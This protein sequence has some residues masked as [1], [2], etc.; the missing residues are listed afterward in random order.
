MDCAIALH[1]P[2]WHRLTVVVVERDSHVAALVGVPKSIW[3]VSVA[4]ASLR[5]H[6]ARVPT[7]VL[8]VAFYCELLYPPPYLSHFL[9][10]SRRVRF[11]SESGGSLSAAA[12]ISERGESGGPGKP[13]VLASSLNFRKRVPVKS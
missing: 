2:T 13:K 6:F 3:V 10:T 7:L 5:R 8:V 11:A 12:H 4:V 1:G 9:L